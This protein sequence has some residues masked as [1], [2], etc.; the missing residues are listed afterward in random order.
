VEYAGGEWPVE[1]DVGMPEDVGLL[2]WTEVEAVEARTGA[3]EATD[4]TN[5]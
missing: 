2:I 1:Y 4:L 5:R 3:C